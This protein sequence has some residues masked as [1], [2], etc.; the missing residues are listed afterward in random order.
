MSM[1]ENLVKMNN[2]SV[3][4]YV[5]V[6]L[7][8]I[9]VIFNLIIIWAIIRANRRSRLSPEDIDLINKYYEAMGQES[10]LKK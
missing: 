1:K 5:I 10:P 8:L 4:V 9:F 7:C 2:Q 3:P 6:I